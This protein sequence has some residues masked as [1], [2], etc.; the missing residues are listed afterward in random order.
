VTA[1]IGVIGCGWWSTFA[2]LPALA[3]DERAEVAGVADLDLE[4][5]AAAAERFGT[6]AFAS[7]AELLESVDLD[8]VVVAVPHVAHHEVA[9]RALEADL[10]VLLEKPMV[11]EPQHG[12]ELIDLARVRGRELI[13]GY[14]WSY[15]AQV[16]AVRDGL[17]AGR[18]G[19]LEYVTSLFASIV[20]ELYAGRPESYR[21][22]FGYPMVGPAATTYSDPAVA[23]GGQAQTQ[24]THSA[25]LLLWMT[26]LEVERVTA[27]TESFELAVDLV[28]AAAV[29]FSGDALGLIGSTGSV[30]PEHPEL[31]EYRIFGTDGHVLFDVNR[32]ELAW[33]TRAG[34]ER[35]E[36]L[37]ESERYPEAAPAR[38]LVD[39]VLGQG[40]NGSP[41]EIGLATVE[42][43][44]AIYRSAR[45]GRPVELGAA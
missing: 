29:R 14:P 9:R 1:R 13:I 34:V 23:G 33:H 4:R 32:G 17:A 12:R 35:S 8:G 26:G 44:D 21:E 20:R 11:L 6:R 28:D 16:L 42:L 30:T 19:R 27:L 15:N 24:V 45:D 3:A 39:V 31:F 22:V 10:H 7:P 38:N 25:A 36:V 41:P 5:A 18:I 2:H 37:P 43:V 40:A